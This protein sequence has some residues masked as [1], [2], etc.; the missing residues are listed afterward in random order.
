[1]LMAGFIGVA[2]SSALIEW[3]GLDETADLYVK[4]RA[5]LSCL[6]QW[7]GRTT[8]SGIGGHPDHKLSRIVWRGL[9]AKHICSLV[10]L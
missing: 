8:S 3:L 2:L 5:F 6:S 4:P 10:L 1:M 7:V 9:M